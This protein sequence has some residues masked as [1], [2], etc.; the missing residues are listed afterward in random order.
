MQQALYRLQELTYRSQE[1]ANPS[2]FFCTCMFSEQDEHQ[3]HAD[4]LLDALNICTS[5][6]AEA[7]GA[8]FTLFLSSLRQNAAFQNFLKKHPCDAVNQ[9]QEKL[10]FKKRE[11]SLKQELEALRS[12]PCR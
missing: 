6:L 12:V 11:D 8:E 9:F 1:Q 10:N 5:L 4:S 2:D 3:K 7:N